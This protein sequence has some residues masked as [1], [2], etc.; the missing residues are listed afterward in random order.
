MWE[1]RRLHNKK[2]HSFY[3]S[4]NRVRVIKPRRLRWLVISQMIEGRSSFKVLIGKPT[5]KSPLGRPWRRWE[6]NIIMDLKGIGVNIRRIGLIRLW[7]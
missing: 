6:D 2:L 4:P 5:G 7:I 1:R 3:L